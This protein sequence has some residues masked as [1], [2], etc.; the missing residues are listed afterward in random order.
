M[1]S[2]QYRANPAEIVLA[3]EEG[4]LFPGP[5]FSLLIFNLND[6]RF[7]CFAFIVSSKIA[8]KAVKRNRLKRTLRDIV[9]NL[10]SETKKGKIILFLAKKKIL[11]R[12]I[13]TL[14]KEVREMYMKAG[15]V[16]K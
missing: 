1:L 6:N 11:D 12:D 8:K 4:K 3:R 14:G 5:L 7:S 15:V 16:S 9:F 10:L 13:K 2:K